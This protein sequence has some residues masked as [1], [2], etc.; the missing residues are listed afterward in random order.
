MLDRSKIIKAL[1]IHGAGLEQ[2]ISSQHERARELWQRVCIDEMFCAAIQEMSVPYL[3]P[4]WSDRLDKTTVMAPQSTYRVVGVDGSQL[5]PD[6]H[7]G[8]QCFVI[9]VGVVDITYGSATST[10]TFDASPYVSFERG[11][12]REYQTPELVNAVRTEYEFAGGC[13]WMSKNAGVTIP[14][15][16]VFDG[17]LIFW[18]LESSDDT[19]KSKFLPSYIRHLEMLYEYQ[20][21]YAAYISMPKS[22]EIVNILRTASMLQSCG[23]AEEFDHLL[24]TDIMQFLMPGSRSGMFRNH[25]PVT[26]KYPD[27]S[28]PYFFYLNTGNEIARVELPAWIAIDA[29][30]LSVVEGMIYDQV[31]KGNGYPIALSEAHEQAVIT[32]GDK[33]FFYHLL[34][35]MMPHGTASRSQKLMRK[36]KSYV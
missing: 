10:V 34:R 35:T 17:S 12:A 26:K 21:L 4:S 32:M 16:F 24:D 5:Y 11:D 29:N 20:H 27:H 2:Q 19:A 6:R 7:E 36:Y 15:L 1:S 14:Q 8:M 23:V 18:H 13:E 9:N 25:S 22:R 30:K 33:E 31:V 3:M 28:M